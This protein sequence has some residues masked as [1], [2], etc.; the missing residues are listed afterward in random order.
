MTRANL[1]VYA[2][3]LVAALNTARATSPRSG[4][5]HRLKGNALA[6]AGNLEQALVEYQTSCYL[7]DARGCFNLG[8]AVTRG[9]GT[10]P[11]CT[12]GA[13]HFRKACQLGFGRACFAL[14][15]LP[16]ECR[17]GPGFPSR[18]QAF[19][20][21]CRLNEPQG[22]PR[23]SPGPNAP[24]SAPPREPAK[25]WK[26]D[27]ARERRLQHQKDEQKKDDET[28]QRNL[29]D[30]HAQEAERRRVN[31]VREDGERQRKEYDRRRDEEARQRREYDRRRDEEERRRRD[32]ERRRDE[33]DRRRRE[34]DERRRR[35]AE[36]SY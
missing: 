29:D 4:D 26:P 34:D 6:E 17:L 1:C 8:L 23:A 32:D 10:N 5:A 21:A 28:R 13:L 27:P 9:E 33:A 31:Q 16:K 36:R 19:A 18:E 14:G 15:S 35:D 30:Y 11:S 24:A 22:C 20:E 7:K 2:L 12:V 3:A 25:W